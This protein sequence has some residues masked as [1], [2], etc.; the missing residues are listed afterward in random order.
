[1]GSQYSFHSLTNEFVG[2]K[3]KE[4][5]GK[6]K[7]IMAGNTVYSVFFSLS[8]TTIGLSTYII[9]LSQEREGLRE[10]KR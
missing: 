2:R 5:K 10:E 7:K 6:E 1:M 8:T 3:E 9:G 4:K